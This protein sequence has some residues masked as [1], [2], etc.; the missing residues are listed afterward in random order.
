MV[1]ESFAMMSAF[2]FLNKSIQKLPNNPGP[3]QL[4]PREWIS[5]AIV[6]SAGHHPHPPPAVPGGAAPPLHPVHGSSVLRLNTTPKTFSQV[7]DVL[8]LVIVIHPIQGSDGVHHPL[9]AS[10]RP[11]LHCIGDGVI[12]NTIEV[13]DRHMGGWQWP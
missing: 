8:L 3:L 13:N 4:V 12:I 11:I 6:P 5:V 10:P 2:L 9:R 7:P 1:L